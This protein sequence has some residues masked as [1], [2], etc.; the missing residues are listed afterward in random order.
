MR[1]YVTAVLLALNILLFIV[2]V[3]VSGFTEEFLLASADITARPWILLTSM[4]LH[5]SPSH[6]LGNMFALAIFGFILESII[7][8]KRYM[9]LYIGGGVFASFLSSFFYESA[10]GA[11][12]AIFVVIGALAA[13]RPGMTVYAMGSPMPMIAAAGLWLLLDIVGVF[14]PSSVAN[15]AHIAGLLFGAVVGYALKQRE[16]KHPKGK[17]EKSISD[18]EFD[19]WEEKWV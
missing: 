15:I 7:G 2:Q 6:L 17:R 19:E 11:S 9:A 13:M 1:G 12:G 14:F 5:G 8:S 10:L 18:D 16:P 4:F 3:A